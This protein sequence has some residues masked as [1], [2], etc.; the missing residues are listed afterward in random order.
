MARPNTREQILEAG[1]KCL[2]AKGFNAVGVQ[3][4]TDAA[5]VPKGSF[6]NHFESKEA[7]GAEIVERY[8]DNQTRRE[9]LADPKVPPL[10]RL[11][12]HFDRVTALFVDS[13]FE[14][15]C[16]LGGFSAELANQSETIR[17]SLH[18]LY[19]LWTKDIEATIAEAQEKGAIQNKTKASDIAAFLLDAYEGALLR[20]RVERSRKPF[21]RFMT[22]AFSQLLV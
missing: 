20:A 14:R 18:K 6:Y 9:I 22:F 19:K 17:E 8:G 1:L 21:E 13:H 16:I 4:I 2:V 15:N 12:R 5:G 7:L 10:Q 3:D 11:R